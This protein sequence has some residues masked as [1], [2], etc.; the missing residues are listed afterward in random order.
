MKNYFLL[1]TVNVTPT[2][3]HWQPKFLFWKRQGIITPLLLPLNPY[4]ASTS[5]SYILS[6]TS[7]DWRVLAYLFLRWK[8]FPYLWS[9]LLCFPIFQLCTC[10][11]LFFFLTLENFTHSLEKNMESYRSLMIFS[12]LISTVF[13]IIPNCSSMTAR[14]FTFLRN[15]PSQLWELGLLPSPVTGNLYLKGQVRFVCSLCHQH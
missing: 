2:G 12:A 15:I 5:S 4:E 6:A 14:E 8:L 1:F 7:Q 9:P 10:I 11:A 3:V 13:L